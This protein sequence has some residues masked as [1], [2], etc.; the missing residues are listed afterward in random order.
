[1]KTC[2]T[3]WN[4]FQTTRQL[5]RPFR[6]LPELETF[7]TIWKINR[8][9]NF[10]FQPATFNTIRYFFWTLLTLLTLLTGAV[11]FFEP[12]QN[13]RFLH[14]LRRKLGFRSGIL[15]T[16]TDNLYCFHGG[17]LEWVRGCKTFCPPKWQ[18]RYLALGS[19][20]CWRNLRRI[21]ISIRTFSRIHK[22]EQKLVL[23]TPFDQGIPLQRFKHFPSKADCGRWIVWWHKA[24]LMTSNVCIRCR[25]IR[26]ILR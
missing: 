6:K 23:P 24:T 17:G 19:D 14:F 11:I 15:L 12:F 9:G 3:N 2:K 22:T 13:L 20:L 8:A 1:M 10:P 5:F 26:L 7:Q 18:W 21:H 16:T 4:L 25:D